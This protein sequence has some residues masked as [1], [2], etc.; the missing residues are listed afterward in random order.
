MPLDLPASTNNQKSEHVSLSLRPTGN[1]WIDT[2]LV[3][4]V[5]QFGEGDYPLR[6]VLGWLLS[7]LV[8]LTGKKGTYYDEATGAFRE[9]DK[10][11]WVYP[12]NLFIKV[13]APHSVKNQNPRQ[14][15]LHRA[16]E[17][18]AGYPAKQETRTV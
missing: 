3:V 14:R 12:T 15:P 4:L 5:R 17:V 10:S 7:Q 2:G 11:N 1:F 13:S 6:Q 16:A 18:H 9:Y 8:Q